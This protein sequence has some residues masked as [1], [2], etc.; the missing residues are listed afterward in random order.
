MPVRKIFQIFFSLVLMFSLTACGNVKFI[1][2]VEETPKP[3]TEATNP[4][5][6]DVTEFDQTDTILPDETDFKETATPEP[7]PTPDLEPPAPD[8]KTVNGIKFKLKTETLYVVVED[9]PAYSNATLQKETSKL[10][11]GSEVSRTGLS[12]DGSISMIKVSTGRTYYMKS[13]YLKYEKPYIATP[14]PEPIVVPTPTPTPTP[15]PATPIP[16]QNNNN[17]NNQS[18][19]GYTQPQPQPT[20]QPTY[21]SCSGVCWVGGTPDKYVNGIGFKT[22]SFTAY[23][24]QTTYLY[25]TPSFSA[26]TEWLASGTELNCTAIGENNFVQVLLA[27]GAYGYIDGNCLRYS[28]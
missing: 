25:S 21:N 20:Q 9:A 10:S 17:G 26:S 2:E 11:L 4:V 14:T 7:T 28:N 13:D 19:G 8:E 23:I 6:H 1:E 5:P 18:G 3:T 24:V 15:A 22:Q 16:Q 12:I 27:N